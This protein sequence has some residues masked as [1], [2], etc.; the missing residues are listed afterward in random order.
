MGFLRNRLDR[1]FPRLGLLSDLALVGTAASRL[2]RRGDTT[3][4]ARA[5]SS[6]ELVLAGGAA[7]RLL[8]R[9]RRRRRSR[10]T[11]AG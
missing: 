7:V 10:V 8:R 5:A 4:P 6:A 3:G 9:W 2:L 11:V 1:R